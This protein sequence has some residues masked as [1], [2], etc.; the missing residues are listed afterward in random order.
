MADIVL[1]NTPYYGNCGGELDLSAS[2]EM[3]PPLGL[4]YV[5]AACNDFSVRIIDMEAK[6]IKI[7]DI[8]GKIVK[9]NPKVI[10][11]TAMSSNIGEIKKISDII[12]EN[13][14]SKIL[15][16][17]PHAILDP[18]SLVDIG[19]YIVC[20][21]AEIMINDLLNYII[22]KKG[23]LDGVKNL[24][25][26]IYGKI[27]HTKKE[28]IKNLDDVPFP[29]RELYEN[30]YYFHV[31][32]KNRP[33]TSIITSR[34]C[35][36]RCIYCTPIYRTMR[37]RSVGNVI[38]EIKEIIEK[39]GIKDLEFF[40]ETFN[41]GEQWVIDFCDRI[42]KEKIK[43]NWRARCRP[44]LITEKSV[45]KMKHAGCYM[46][47]MGVES[48]NDKTLEFFKK[49][50]NLKQI[51][52]A[53]KIIKES[54]IEL[55]GYFILGSPT[56][57]KKE[58]LNTVNFAIKQD[59]DCAGFSILKPHPTTRLMQIALENNWLTTPEIG[60]SKVIKGYCHPTLKHPELTEDEIM[61]ICKTAT[62]KFFMTPKRVSSTLRKIIFSKGV[63]R[64]KIFKTAFNYLMK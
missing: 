5:A 43:I 7:E 1:I 13:S 46:I 59:F 2:L 10:G 9:C 41:L 64:K 30:E 51:K 42:I 55:H 63:G 3:L 28:L 57:S 62:I 24:T 18:E 32:A 39:F 25:Y 12:R 50:Y 33:C 44:D 61:K 56:E 60:H 45:K 47:S 29:K 49:D 26:K 16:G 20:G 31:F 4:G 48:A 54:D 35:P 21:E 27:I 36:Y 23:R 19:D 34:G 22:N 11:L 6:N 17:G 52:N 53:I 38:K 14:S 58:T 8:W 15:I 37:R 40:D